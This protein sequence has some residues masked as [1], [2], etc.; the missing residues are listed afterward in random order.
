MTNKL[1]VQFIII[2]LLL[3]ISPKTLASE[4]ATEPNP[5]ERMIYAEIAESNLIYEYLA[6][7]GVRIWEINELLSNLSINH[8]FSLSKQEKVKYINRLFRG[9][10]VSFWANLP[11]VTEIE[12]SHGWGAHNRTANYYYT[13]CDTQSEYDMSERA[14]RFFVNAYCRTGL[15]IFLTKEN[16]SAQDLDTLYSTYWHDLSNQRYMPVFSLN[17][18][19]RLKAFQSVMQRM[20]A[21]GK[22]C[23][24]IGDD[25]IKDITMETYLQI[26]GAGELISAINIGQA[27]I[28]VA[29]IGAT[30]VKSRATEYGWE[31]A[32]E[33]L[34]RESTLPET[35]HRD[36]YEHMENEFTKAT[37]TGSLSPMTT[38]QSITYLQHNVQLIPRSINTESPASFD[39]NRNLIEPMKIND[40]L[41]IWGRAI[42][43][44]LISGHYSASIRHEVIH[45]SLVAQ[46]AITALNYAN[47]LRNYGIESN[48]NMSAEMWTEFFAQYELGKIKTQR[49]IETLISSGNY[50]YYDNMLRYAG[51]VVGQISARRNISFDDAVRVVWSFYKGQSG[52][53]MTM[54]WDIMPHLGYLNSQ[55]FYNYINISLAKR[56]IP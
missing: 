27:E 49:D 39:A 42:D 45:S 37:T 18:V 56:A 1:A 44:R 51:R 29:E 35:V 55:S 41:P 10:R 52:D 2:S 15:T 25:A 33:G 22:N 7:N 36:E 50:A 47:V 16:W 46:P 9:R 5:A 30:L 23:A 32:R 24:A 40:Q 53:L 26:T 28:A 17:E 8:Y 43:G 34:F 19:N 3:F 21:Q 11:R 54:Y 12:S 13:R 14:A 31:L 20:Y 48:P 6:S 4:V 38:K